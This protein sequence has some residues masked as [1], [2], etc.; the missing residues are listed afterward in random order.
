L[1]KIS[2]KGLFGPFSGFWP[3]SGL[4]TQFRDPARGGFYINPSRRGP[5]PGIWRFSGVSPGRP[6]KGLFWRFFPKFG[7]M[8][9]F[10][11]P[12]GVWDPGLPGRPQPGDRAPA[13]GVDV[14]PPSRG[15]PGRGA[16]APGSPG[17]AW[18]P[19]RGPETSRR[20]LR[21][22][23]GGWYPVPGL[24]RAGVLHQPLAAGPCPRPGDPSRAPGATPPQEEG[25]GV[26]PHP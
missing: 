5:V 9:V 13:R 18:T 7:E 8:G 25:Q 12:E 11:S 15:A 22:P 1:P 17:Q 19:D 24:P 2:E 21:A 6:Q 20:P 14:K 10:Q 4:F 16:R 3:F 26:E 23:P